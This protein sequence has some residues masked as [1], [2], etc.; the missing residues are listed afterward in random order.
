MSSVCV[1]MLPVE[2][3]MEMRFWNVEP[4]SDSESVFCREDA[5]FTGAEGSIH[6][7]PVPAEPGGEKTLREV[8]LLPLLLLLL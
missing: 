1:P 7:T 6:P 8:L 3:K 5:V 2:P 4:F